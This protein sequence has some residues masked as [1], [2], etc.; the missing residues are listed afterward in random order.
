MTVIRL[1]AL[2]TVA[3]F[4]ASVITIGNFDGVHRGHQAMV[5]RVMAHA[6]QESLQ[7]VVLLFEPQPQEFF[8]GLEAPPRIT[9]WREK[10]E[11]LYQLGI[12]TIV[13]I[14][15][16]SAFRHLSAA[17][18]VQLLRARLNARQLVIG[19]DFRFGC[20]RVGDQHFLREA[21]F[22]VETLDTLIE[23]PERISSTWIRQA[24]A[25]GNFPL[26]GQLLGRPYEISGRV[27]YG[28]QIG[29][30]LDFPTANIALNRPQP[31][32]E[33]IYAVDVMLCHAKQRWQA[34]AEGGISG[35]S[36]NSLFGAAHVGK[37]PAIHKETADEWRL[38][39]HLPGVSQAMLYGCRLTVRFRHFLHGV[40]PYPSLAALQLGIAQD[41]RELV[42][43]QA[44]HSSLYWPIQS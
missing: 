23:G 20:D 26:A 32:L 5:A 27:V 18:F 19:D 22:R 37:R 25:A 8:R 13:L 3:D 38:E 1:H 41:V 24:L 33:G 15:F 29:R 40:R 14:R 4:P 36:P 31:C 30:T 11:Q 42:A 7:P 12:R 44:R 6:R 16:D 34:V 28:D 35:F 10:V 43:L 2:D 39:V 17:Q 21:G 9:S